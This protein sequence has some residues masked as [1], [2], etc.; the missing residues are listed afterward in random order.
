[1]Q[2]F[3]RRHFRLILLLGSFLFIGVVAWVLIYTFVIFHVTAVEPSGSKVSIYQPRF[4]ITFN[5]D[6]SSDGLSVKIDNLQYETSIKD[7]VLTIDVY[8]YMEADTPYTFTIE[9]V[10]SKS[11]DILRNYKINFT[12]SNDNSLISEEANKI[13]LDR[14]DNKAG[15]L[16]D[17]IYSHIPHSTLDYTINARGGTDSSDDDNKTTII[18][19]INLSAADVKSGR[20]AAVEL[21]K[22]DAM[23]YL[24]SLSDIDLSSYIIEVN[25]IEPTL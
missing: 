20:D 25:V 3:L 16:S 18:I 7:N 2:D 23:E 1:M 5:K 12:A 4:T 15:L 6:L 11:G 19:T 9:S 10:H 22:Q 21:Y 13:I 8:T 17:P 14:Q 24:Q